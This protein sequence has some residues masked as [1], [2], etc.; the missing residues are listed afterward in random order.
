MNSDGWRETTIGDLCEI[1]SSKRIYLSDYVSQGIPFYRSKEIIQKHNNDEITTELFITKDKYIEIK[2]KFGV[3]IEGDILLTSVGTLGIPY[4]V[5]WDDLFYFKDGN[6]TWFRNLSYCLDS[7]YLYYF[8]CSDLGKQKL[9]EITIGSTQKALTIESLKKIKLMLPPS[10]EQ[11]AIAAVF[12]A[13]DDKIKLNNRI[14]KTLEEMAQAIFKSWFID[15]EPL[16]GKQ[17]SDLK[18][19]FLGDICDFSTDRIAVSELTLKTY[20]STENILQ[21]KSGYVDASS[22]PSSVQTTMFKTG[23]ILVS[24]IRPYFMKIIYCNFEGGCSTDVLCFRPRSPQLSQFLYCC[25][26]NDKFFDFMVSGSKGTKMPRGDKQHIMS[27]PI[28]IPSDKLLSEF[29]EI[30]TNFLRKNY[31]I[32]LENIRLSILRDALLPHLMS[33]ELSVAN[34][35]DV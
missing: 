6:L 9:E 19:G 7:K 35:D 12:S 8:F 16:G 3:P 33:G 23:D 28:V 15:F 1:T 24:N 34:I 14:N 32:T 2:R 4:I 26:Y 5:K 25:L 10:K 11:K 27:Y 31:L 21:N 17:P 13:L 29:S 22:L 20:I 18:S 30:V